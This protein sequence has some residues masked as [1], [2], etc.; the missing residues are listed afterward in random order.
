MIHLNIP[1]LWQNYLPLPGVDSHKYTRGYSLVIGG[2]ISSTGAARLAA[3]S[4]LR[5]G[6]G[7]V[8][9]ACDAKSLPVYA[10]SLL[11]VMLKLANNED[12]LDALLDNKHIST[13]LIGPG[14]G[15][16][17]QT[18]NQTLRI[19][20][21]KKPCVI[22]ADAISV[23][24]QAPDVLFSAI[25]GPVVMTPHEAEF[26]RLFSLQ[27]TR[28]DRACAAAKTSNAC[29][30]L[31][32]HHTI[33][34]APDGQYVI[35]KNAPAWLATAGSGD[36]LAGMIC[37]L[38]AQGVGAFHAACMAVW[39]HGRAAEIFGAGLIAEDLPSLIPEVWKELH[40]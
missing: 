13:V 12:E 4:A 2:G 38:L 35:N 39:M 30:V 18:R 5:T 23:F 34:A 25:G 24:S 22:D 10:A 15:V 28:E 37:G 6:S 14:C 7:L 27:G 19:L 3:L 36:V 11:S 9:I 33:I 1:A 32:G 16:S 29:I 31:K 17:E 8:S 40:A 20:S 26:S 21:H